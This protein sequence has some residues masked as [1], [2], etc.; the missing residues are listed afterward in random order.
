MITKSRLVVTLIK[1]PGEDTVNKDYFRWVNT[2][3]FYNLYSKVTL[4]SIREHL[5]A[6]ILQQERNRDA[7]LLNQQNH[8]FCITTKSQHQSCKSCSQRGLPYS[9]KDQVQSRGSERSL[10][11]IK[12]KQTV[13]LT[14]MHNLSKLEEKWPHCI[15]HATFCV[16]WVTLM[17][18]K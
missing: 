9:K 18:C 1:I 11:L 8:K 17:L 2:I 14:K 4:V 10:I 7:V 12:T 13:T 3:I 16:I 5:N 15:Q 6:H